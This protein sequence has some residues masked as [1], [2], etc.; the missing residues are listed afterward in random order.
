MRE[1]TEECYGRYIS[2]EAKKGIINSII[3]L[4]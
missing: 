4:I 3:L 2:M 1:D